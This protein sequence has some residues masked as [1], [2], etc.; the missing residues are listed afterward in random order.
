M[1]ALFG[2]DF[3]GHPEPEAID[4]LCSNTGIFDM[5]LYFFTT[6]GQFRRFEFKLPYL[7][8]FRNYRLL[9]ISRDMNI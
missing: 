7:V 6:N 8:S 1:L 9:E 2:E 3:F 4:L 5:E